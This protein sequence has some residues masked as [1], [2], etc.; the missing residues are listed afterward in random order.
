M[1][2]VSVVIIVQGTISMNGPANVLNITYERGRLDFFEYV[3]S[4]LIICRHRA[5]LRTRARIHNSH[6]IANPLKT[7]ELRAEFAVAILMP[8]L[9]NY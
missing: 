5:D 2:G 1:I 3:F 8:E 9:Y 4:M 7:S 6:F